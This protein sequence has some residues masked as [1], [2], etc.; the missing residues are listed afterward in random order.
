MG[1]IALLGLAGGVSAGATALAAT[2]TLLPMAATSAISLGSIISSLGSAFSLVQGFAESRAVQ[3]QGAAEMSSERYNMATQ[4]LQSA[5]EEEKMRR[6]QYLRSGKQMAASGGQGRGQGG[7]ILDIMS[8]TAYQSELDIL[9]LRTASEMN[10]GMSSSKIKNIKN[11]TSLSSASSILT[12]VTKLASGVS[13]L[14]DE[15]VI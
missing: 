13:R 6:E 9:G 2:G 5:Q 12:G 7:N 14:S 15:G 3:Q 4:R 8:D 1:K 11:S 10:Q